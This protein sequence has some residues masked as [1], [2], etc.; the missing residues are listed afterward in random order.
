MGKY[1]KDILI[2]DLLYL[3]DCVNKGYRLKGGVE[4]FVNKIEESAKGR[5]GGKYLVYP[6]NVCSLNPSIGLHDWSGF[7]IYKNER[8]SFQCE[9]CRS[10]QVINEVTLSPNSTIFLSEVIVLKLGVGRIRDVKVVIVGSYKNYEGI[11]ELAKKY[12]ATGYLI[13]T[14]YIKG[15]NDIFIDIN[16]QEILYRGSIKSIQKIPETENLLKIN[17]NEIRKA[18]YKANEDNSS[19]KLRCYNKH[20]ENRQEKDVL[21]FINK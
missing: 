11:L 19:S 10:S 8:N 14:E 1:N 21:V 15:I 3:A 20:D 4:G 16:A 13:G 7:T 9:I 5:F 18:S 6:D 12:N 2:V 17:E